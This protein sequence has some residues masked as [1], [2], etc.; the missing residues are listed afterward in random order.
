LWFL[1]PAQPQR[2][3]GQHDTARRFSGSYEQFLN[4][5]WAGR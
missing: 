5:G 3:G 4:L 1:F 2:L